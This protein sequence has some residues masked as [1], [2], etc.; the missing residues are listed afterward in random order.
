M[1]VAL[2]VMAMIVLILVIKQLRYPAKENPPGRSG[3]FI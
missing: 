1:E 2:T 3:G